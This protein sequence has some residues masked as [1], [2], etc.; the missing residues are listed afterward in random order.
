MASDPKLK[1]LLLK[2]A[3][4]G[5]K[6]ETVSEASLRQ[7]GVEA[8]S[9]RQVRDALDSLSYNAEFSPVVVGGVYKPPLR[10]VADSGHDG[11]A[12]SVVRYTPRRLLTP[13]RQVQKVGHFVS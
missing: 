8:W 1:E 6:F 9:C 10:R 4:Q 2:L 13:A 5:E 12:A 7:W 3:A 11:G